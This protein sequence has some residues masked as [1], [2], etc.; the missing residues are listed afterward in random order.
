MGIRSL[1]TFVTL[2]KSEVTFSE[3][4][5]SVSGGQR[6]RILLSRACAFLLACSCANAQ[7]DARIRLPVEEGAGL[8]FTAVP[9]GNGPSHATVTQIVEDATGFLWFGTNDGLK[10]YDG[11]RFRDFRPDSRNHDSLSG[12][13]VEAV[14]EDRSGKLWVSSDLTL[15]RYDP[16]TETFTHFPSKPLLLEGPIHHIKQDRA[17]AIWL[18]TAYG[19]NRIDP[20]TGAMT[21]YLTGP[22]DPRF[23]RSTFEQRDGTFWV[24]SQESLDVFDRQ[25]G[26][27][28]EHFSLRDPA[29]A[30]AG[31]TPNLSVRLLE[32]HLG[33]VW[34]GSDRDGLAKVDR[35]NNQLIYF[36]LNP[37]HD[38]GPEPGVRAIYEDQQHALWIGTNGAGL[39]KLDGDRKKF[40]RYRNNPSDP[41]SISND[42]ILALYEDHEGEIWAGT[43]GGGV[44]RFPVRPAPFHR[45]RQPPRNRN[46]LDTNYVSSALEDSRGSI[47]AGGKGVV[48]RIDRKTGQFSTYPIGGTRE[49]VSNAGVLSIVEDVSG[50]LWLATWGEGLHRFDPRTEQWKVYRHSQNDLSSLSRDSVFALFIDHRGALW[51][52]TEDGL[53]AFDPKTDRF[54]HYR[55]DTLGSNRE[56]AIVE[57]SEG[58]LWLG[59]LYNGLHRFNPA[60]GQFTVYRHSEAAGSLSN[61]AVNAVCVD[62]S[63]AV[64][65]G[66]VNGLNR[67]DPATQTFSTYYESDGLAGNNVNGVVEDRRGDLWVTTS[68]GLSRFNR[69]SNAFQSFFSPDGVPGDLTFAWKSRSGEIFLGSYAGLTTFFPGGGGGEPVYHSDGAH[70]LRDV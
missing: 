47:W 40:I 21:R 62:H 59:T 52:G 18:A 32:D 14:F 17:G 20:A 25:T 63:G 43:D 8:A 15:D 19:L 35:K 61:D 13:I 68:D 7:R 65:A 6:R 39:Y 31:R 42:R 70:Q 57:D 50:K 30:R 23:L 10:R 34:L 26:K 69:R 12:L 38:P 2:K 60:T 67:F 46:A 29:A 49:R 9:F 66:T 54:E 33:T 5:T 22:N 51:V 1:R 24:A 45:Y 44:A 58:A 28:T 3:G 64:W 53:D 11:Y 27:V 55:V 56:R 41:E 4:E 16:A 48:N 37:R 36:D